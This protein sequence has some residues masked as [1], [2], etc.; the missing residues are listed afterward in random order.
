MREIF[1]QA[2][3]FRN[4][5]EEAAAGRK[6]LLVRL[7]VLGEVGDFRREDGDLHLRGAGVGRVRLEFLD[8]LLL[9]VF[10]HHIS[11]RR[12]EFVLAGGETKRA[13]M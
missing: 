6:V 10:V 13:V 9:G 3:A 2:A 11:L 7:Q 1:E 5:F 12:A 4:L 8:D